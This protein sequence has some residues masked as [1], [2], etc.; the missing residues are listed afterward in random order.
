MSR[1]DP[2]RPSTWS[3]GLR[4]SEPLA[5]GDSSRYQ[6][7]SCSMS[8]R[9]RPTESRDCF[10][11]DV[12]SRALLLR[13]VRSLLRSGRYVHV[14]FCLFCLLSMC[15]CRGAGRGVL[16]SV[17]EAPE[18]LC[19]AVG[20]HEKDGKAFCRKD[21]FDMFAPKCGGCARAILENYISALNALWH[22]ECF[23]CRV[24]LVGLGS[25]LGA[26]TA[27]RPP[28]FPV[29]VLHALHQRQLL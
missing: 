17:Q 14:C 21:Y 2:S 15:V 9:L 3:L 19:S 29:G 16:V 8:H 23:V 4:H 13:P 26:G 18:C 22:P 1:S 20:F 28:A 12:A 11:Q 10:G 25:S 7:V 27:H 6:R 5:I 24:S